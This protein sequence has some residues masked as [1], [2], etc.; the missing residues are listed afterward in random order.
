MATTTIFNNALKLMAKGD[1]IIPAN[2]TH[3]VLLLSTSSTYSASKSHV[4]VADILSNGGIEVSP[5]NGYNTTG[6]TIATI[7]A[8]IVSGT[9]NINITFSDVSWPNSTIS[10]NG[11]VIYK[12]G[13]TGTNGY[14]DAKLIAH[15]GFGTTISSSSSA[16]TLTFSSPLVLAN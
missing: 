3:K 4:Y 16:F 2:A 13:T 11:A 12:P 8:D 9:N 10:A 15:I 5:G 7:V 1:L 6:Q 14:T